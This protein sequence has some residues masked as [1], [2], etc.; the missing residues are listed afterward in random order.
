MTVFMS[1]SRERMEA[2]VGFE[3][4]GANMTSKE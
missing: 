3:Q 4:Q 2:M 1:K